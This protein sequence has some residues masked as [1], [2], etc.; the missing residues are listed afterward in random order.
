MLNTVKATAHDGK[1]LQ[2]RENDMFTSDLPK[3]CK[4]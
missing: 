4:T 2:L 1:K 3:S